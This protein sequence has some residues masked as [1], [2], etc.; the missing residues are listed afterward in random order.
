MPRRIEVELTSSR[1]DGTWT[2]RAPGAREPRGD[3]D[4]T[5]LYDGASVGDIVRADAEFDIDGITL[6]AVLPPKQRSGSE[7]ERLELIAP[8]REEPPVTGPKTNSG[9]DGQKKGARGGPKKR[10]RDGRAR[11]RDGER[12]RKGTRAKDPSGRPPAEAETGPRPKRLR[13]GRAHRKAA[14]DGLPPEQQRV[15][16]QVLRG[17]VPAVR[18]AVAKQNEES[19]ASGKPEVKAEALV[20]LGEKLLPR[21]RTA[22]WHDRADAALAD[23]DEVDLRDLRSVVVASDT[24]ARDEETRHLATTLRESLARRVEV[25]HGKWLAE[26]KTTIDEGRVVR[27]LRLSSHPPKAGVPLPPDLAASLA[28]AAGKALSDDVG[29]DRWATILDATAYSPVRQAV[30]PVGAPSAPGDELMQVVRRHSM[31][32]PEI[33]AS[34]GVK[35]RPPPKRSRRDQRSR[36]D[37]NRPKP[38]QASPAETAR[39]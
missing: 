7:P 6:I 20:D 32:L 29:Q 36:G 24:A 22:E 13:A 8:E 28:D 2:W 17:G 35:P 1:D 4:G 31:A 12:K 30:K 16:E 11:E 5:L 18:K 38:A 9:R 15:A 25:E 33:A 14:L 21:L 3:L 23:V 19:V 34:F 39:G 27:A 26:L 37:R 10:G